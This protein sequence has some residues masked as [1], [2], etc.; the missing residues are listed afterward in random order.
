[1]TKKTINLGE[2]FRQ[3]LKGQPV[4]MSK[5]RARKQKAKRKVKE[6]LSGIEGITKVRNG[7]YKNGYFFR[8]HYFDDNNKKK[9]MQSITLKK[10]YDKMQDK[11][12]DFTIQDKKRARMFVYDNCKKEDYDFFLKLINNIR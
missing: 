2:L 6:R 8:Y 3:K 11:G 1:M 10:L 7:D 9:S 5:K 4:T 12:I